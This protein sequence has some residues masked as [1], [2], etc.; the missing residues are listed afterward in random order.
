MAANRSLAWKVQFEGR[1]KGSFAG[2]NNNGDG[3]EMEMHDYYRMLLKKGEA[4][5]C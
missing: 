1:G 3:G 2:G 4:G 5:A